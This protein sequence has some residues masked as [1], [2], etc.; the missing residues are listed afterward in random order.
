MPGYDAISAPVW[1]AHGE[2][3]YAITIT[4]PRDR[5]EAGPRRWLAEQLLA[6][7]TKLS[8]Q[9]GAPAHLWAMSPD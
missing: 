5:I 1:D 9:F 6:S 7:S 8:R 2:I 3:C 4:G